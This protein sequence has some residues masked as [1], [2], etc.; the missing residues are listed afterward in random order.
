MMWNLRMA[1]GGGWAAESAGG[2]RRRRVE[3]GA[4]GNRWL[5]AQ[6]EEND[7]SIH[8]PVGDVRRQPQ[9]PEGLQQPGQPALK[10]G[11][12]AGVPRCGHDGHL[13]QRGWVGAR[14]SAIVTGRLPLSA[15]ACIV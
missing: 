1:G 13:W 15:G 10:L 3:S 12:L 6:L 7:S 14:V 4:Q 11:G 8:P 9:H 2:E 5:R